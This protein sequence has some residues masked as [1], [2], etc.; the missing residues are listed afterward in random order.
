MAE[1]EGDKITIEA[2]QL[3][4]VSERRQRTLSSRPFC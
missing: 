2:L 1:G 3:D 4:E